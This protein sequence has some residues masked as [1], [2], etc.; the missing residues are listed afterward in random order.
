MVLGPYAAP[1]SCATAFLELFHRLFAN[2][3]STWFECVDSIVVLLSRIACDVTFRCC[4]LTWRTRVREASETKC[5]SACST[6]M[7]HPRMSLDNTSDSIGGD[8]FDAAFQGFARVMESYSIHVVAS[9]DDMVSTNT[10]Q[11]HVMIMTDV[12]CQRCLTNPGTTYTV[13]KDP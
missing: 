10:P 11:R 1:R 12:A 3:W 6:P 4:C 2:A 5:D 8:L 9:T 13:H 7:I